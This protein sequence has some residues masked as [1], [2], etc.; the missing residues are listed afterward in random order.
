MKQE[1]QG[2]PFLCVW[3]V[4]WKQVTPYAGQTLSGKVIA[5]FSRGREVFRE[6]HHAPRPCGTPLLPVHW[7]LITGRQADSHLFTEPRFGFWAR[8]QVICLQNR[9]MGSELGHRSSF[10]QN[11]FL[12]VELGIGSSFHKTEI[13]VLSWVVG[14]LLT[15][16]RFGL[17]YVT[18]SVHVFKSSWLSD[19]KL[20]VH[21][22][23]FS[24]LLAYVAGTHGCWL[25]QHQTIGFLF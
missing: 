19:T 11:W 6:G 16:L 5:T 25:L 13:W 9:D 20:V 17:F 14:H 23:C 18:K 1:K 21:P 4:F 3:L 24:M 7:C 12:G 8:Q 10:L 22:I 15:E 2:C